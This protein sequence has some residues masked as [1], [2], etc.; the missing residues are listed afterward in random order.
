[1]DRMP[2]ESSTLKS[3]GYDP[4]TSTLEVE[5]RR[6]AIYQYFDVPP[7]VYAQLMSASSHGQFFVHHIRN[8]FPT[9]HVLT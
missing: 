8:H 5:F 9:R 4:E 2:V 7:D 6:G 1:M 3:I